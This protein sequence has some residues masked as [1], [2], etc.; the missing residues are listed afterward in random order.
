MSNVVIKKTGN[1]FEVSDGTYTIQGPN[2]SELLKIMDSLEN[3]P[4]SV[5]KIAEKVETAGAIVREK[6]AA[7]KQSRH[8]AI[9]SLIE[10]K[11]QVTAADVIEALA[12]DGQTTSQWGYLLLTMQ[13]DE[14]IL[15]RKKV[16]GIWVYSL[17]K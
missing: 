17:R 14:K 16:D 12:K 10:K 13:R 15:K 4:A 6:V 3:Q 9:L 7:K 11:G 1:G 5:E 2:R 8:E